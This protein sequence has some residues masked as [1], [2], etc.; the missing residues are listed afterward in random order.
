MRKKRQENEVITIY[1]TLNRADL[2]IFSPHLS[3]S[4]SPLHVQNYWKMF[5]HQ[6]TRHI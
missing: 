5:V 4:L 1:A 2:Y 6:H 3:L